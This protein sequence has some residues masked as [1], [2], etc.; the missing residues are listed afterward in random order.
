VD[1]LTGTPGEAPPEAP[2][3]PT[4]DQGQPEPAGVPREAEQP[5]RPATTATP[6]GQ[7]APADPLDPSSFRSRGR[8]RRRARFLRK[9][10]ELAYRDLGGLVFNLH[11]FGQRNDPL[12]LAKLGTL[13]QIDR[14]LRALESAL[15]ERRAITV[16]REAGIAACARCAAIHGSE[17]R[18]C[19]NCGLPIARHAELPIAGPASAA[20]TAAA[21]AS[22]TPPETP[23]GAAP[24]QAG[25]DVPAPPAG[26]A[27]APAHLQ[28]ASSAQDAEPGPRSA[29]PQ[30][31]EPVPGAGPPDEA[32]T[33]IRRTRR[34]AP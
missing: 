13:E 23:A 9:A 3:E 19:P 28:G 16:L 32:P 18:F 33:E 30:Q 21:P 15:G 7:D 1:H 25:G 4:A 14:D 12:V 27:P 29:P 5:Q 6:A 10:R 34:K 31:P 17:D 20:S 11:R 26:A 8:M 2:P 22:S 24:A